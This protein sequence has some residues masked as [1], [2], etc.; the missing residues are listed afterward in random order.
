MEIGAALRGRKRVVPFFNIFISHAREDDQFAQRLTEMLKGQGVSAFSDAEVAVGGDWGDHLRRAIDGSAAVLVLISRDAL[1]SPGVLSEIGAALASDKPIISVVPPNQRV[2]HDMPA[3]IGRL[4]L[5]RAD[6]MSDS[7][8]AA[9]I[10]QSLD[11][12][13]AEGSH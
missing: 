12:L 3:P 5:L 9:S 1:R 7:E 10:R 13:A 2:P 8:I 11:H 6:Q 4:P